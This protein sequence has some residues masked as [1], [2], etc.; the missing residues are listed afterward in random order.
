MKIN[1][2]KGKRIFAIFVA[3][4]MII[5][6]F[7]LSASAAGEDEDY[8]EIYTIE[9]L[10][11][12]RDDLTANYKLM[13]DIDL[14]EATAKGGDYDFYGNGWNPIGSNDV[15]GDG[16]FS[17]IFDGNGHTIKGMRI[18][19]TT[20]PDGT[21]TMYV[22]LFSN[23]SGTVKNFSLQSEIYIKAEKSSYIGNV[24]GFCS[25]N[26]IISNITVYG[27]IMVNNYY[28]YIYTGGMVGYTDDNVII[29]NVCN[30]SNLTVNTYI[31]GVYDESY[32]ARSYVGGITG[33]AYKNDIIHNS[34]N[35]ATI[36]LTIPRYKSNL[37]NHSYYYSTASGYASG[38]CGWGNYSNIYNCYNSASISSGIATE[39][40]DKSSRYSAG[41]IAGG[42]Y[43]NVDNCYNSGEVIGDVNLSIGN[44]TVKNSY[45]L[46]D[47]GTSTAGATSLTEAQMKLQ[48][49]YK[50]FDFENVWV[51]NPYANYPYPQL[52]DN[53][54]DLNEKVELIRIINLPT[55]LDYYTD[56]VLDFSGSALEVVYISGK[57]EILQID[58]SMIS[59]YDPK[60]IGAQEIT[61]TYGGQSDTYT[62]NVTKRPDI[63]SLTLKTQPDKTSF[64]IGTKFDLSGAELEVAYENGVIVTIPVTDDMVSGGN[65]NH[66][67]KYTLTIT[68][69]GKEVTVDVDVVSIQVEKIEITKLPTKINY[70]EGQI[71]DPS[72]ME[73]TAEFNNGKK[74]SV[75]SG[76]ELEGYSATIGTH[77]ITVSYLGFTDTF[78]VVVRE[79]S[80]VNLE[81]KSMPEKTVYYTGDEL[82]TTGLVIEATYDN[83]DVEQPTDY[84]VTGF[85]NEP[86]LH[87]IE[88]TYDGLKVTFNVNIIKTAISKLTI[89]QKPIKT[90]YL[91]NESFDPT[92]LIVTAEYNNGD[93]K[94]VDDYQLSEFE[95]KAGKQNITVSYEGKT[96]EFSVTVI[97]KTA[98]SI[99]LNKNT[100]SLLEGG[101]DVLIATVS[102]DDCTDKVIWQSS[103]PDVASV[104]GGI[105]TA[106]SHGST[107]ISATAGQKSAICLVTVA[108]DH[109]I[110]S[111]S[112]KD[113]T[114]KEKG[115]EAYKECQKCHQ[116]FAVDGVTEIKS[117][118]YKE[119][120][121]QHKGGTA[122]CKE[123]AVCEICGQSYGELGKHTLTYHTA[124]DAD[125]T[126][127]GNIGYYECTC[128]NKYYTDNFA[129]KEIQPSETVIPQIKHTYPE[130]WSKNATQHWHECECG[131]K[132]NISNHSYDNDCD[133]TCNVC[134]YVRTITHKYKTVWS[135]DGTNHWH[136]CSVCGD[137]IDEEAHFGGV[138]TCTN[139]AICT[140]CGKAYGSYGKHR[141]THY[142]RV[143][144]THYKP[145]NIEYW[146]CETCKKYFDDL[147]G[148]NEIL[149]SDTVIPQINHSYSNTWSSDGSSHWHECSCGDKTDVAVHITEVRGYVAPTC[150]KAG[151]TGDTYCKICGVLVSKGTN[152]K[153]LG[154]K[155]A[156]KTTK[157][158]YFAK[159]KKQ[160]VCK[161]CGELLKTEDIP[162]L[163]LKTPTVKVTSKK[164][165]L[166]IKVGKVTGQTGFQIRYRLKGKKKW[167][168][169][170]FTTKKA[171]TKT[172]KKLKGK[173]SYQIQ[174]RAMVKSG[175]KKAYSSWSKTYTKKTK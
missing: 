116:L 34:F 121:T 113:S 73:V 56:D 14:T 144:A 8:K 134:G 152:V 18:N 47:T 82:N 54:Q 15:Y 21:G 133:T 164:K 118:P 74:S 97:E 28:S 36:S 99:T 163:K 9:D 109:D 96:A 25:D 6:S 2:L 136:E 114:C 120:S 84:T 44:A 125:H 45:Y 12:V 48:S 175:S 22:G 110:K 174:V 43:L 95:N 69:F 39:S 93:I 173:K 145:G 165:A 71:F 37:Y 27:N 149:S 66:L 55:K 72:G 138:A 53:I 161:V 115:W 4:A 130:T 61:V 156:I 60:K 77:T 131:A 88:V 38:I 17:G 168:T 112:A 5:C 30:N 76:Y 58:N 26:G 155:T 32:G 147:N 80:I 89:T 10:Y 90:T 169:K 151:Y 98:T 63:T 150:E 51:I 140:A 31:R 101:A 13:N 94:N 41:I 50:G 35:E 139:K 92:G 105:V 85:D 141:L 123:K 126:K 129:T 127:P 108:C 162:M 142:M 75:T 100:L 106:I 29:S 62:I 124:V 24:A 170:T 79:K 117:I 42:S 3:V 64:A 167:V 59:G 46:A 19:I 40:N 57:D 52:R 91:L 83:G 166:S 86:G 132:S 119:L 70:I 103:N 146:Y 122:T 11:N 111:I 137:K 1:L 49:M 158:T 171:V 160:T 20:V 23:I 135:N 172:I 33:Y 16:E 154:H 157:A 128:C 143:E 107:V 67:G 148:N 81:L 104:S 7:P 65:I 153:A 78:D 68:F 102:P 87:V 159:G